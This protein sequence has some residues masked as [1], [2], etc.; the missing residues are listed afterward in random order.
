VIDTHSEVQTRILDLQTK[1]KEQGIIAAL[2]Q[3]PRNLYYYTL[4]GQPSNLWVPA[5]GDPIL[6]TRRV[7]E[8][9][10]EQTPIENVFP[11][12]NF[13]EM[14]AH[15]AEMNILPASNHYIGA[16][17]DFLPYNLIKKIE[18]SFPDQKLV[19]ITNITMEQRFVKS[20]GEVE[21]IRESAKLWKIAHE[22]ILN[23]GKT[24]MKEHE[25][26]AIFEYEARKNGGDGS[27]WFHRWDA[28]LPGGGIVAAGE[29]AWTISG[30]AMTVTGVGMSNVLPWGSSERKIQNGDLMVVDY[31]I[32]KQGYHSDMARTYA[33]GEATNKQKDLWNKLVELHLQIIKQV[34]PGVTGAELYNHALK[35]AQ[36][37]N[38][39]ENFMGIGE[40][41]G[42]YL[43]HSIG[44]ELDE[45][46]VIGPKATIPLKENNII[47][48][49]PKF[50]VPE[51]GSV[52]VEDDILVTSEGHEIIGEIGHEL[53]E[54]K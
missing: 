18:S 30:H 23:H 40:N 11:A 13:K 38:L 1:L 48:L 32:A 49:E 17:I 20:D 47:T 33:I 6:F 36:Q 9:T 37:M 21:Q 2:I 26:A 28:Y 39:E 51:I 44:L 12:S 27:V 3:K 24:G 22:A 14:K 41:R 54:I 5:E 35:I 29:N 52:M 7:H 15:L 10:R 53:F 16:E 42:A 25:I 31:G 8:L 4:T 50:M 34:R 46:P 45:F 43:G 19:N